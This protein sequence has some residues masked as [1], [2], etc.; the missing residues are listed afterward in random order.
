[1][2]T[3]LAL[4][5]LCLPGRAEDLAPLPAPS[6][7]HAVGT[8]V[9]VLA[10]PERAD[11]VEPEE[12]PRTLVVQLWYPLAQRAA[13][14]SGNR[15]A[16]VDGELLAAFDE[17]SYYGQGL[18]VLADWEGRATHALEDAP[19]RAGALPL[20]LLSHGLGVSRVHYAALAQDLASHGFA[21]A[22]PDHPHGGVTVL[23]DGRVLASDRDPLLGTAGGFGQRASEWARDL[24]LLLDRLPAALGADVALDTGRV[25]AIGHS[26]GGSAAIEATR[27]DER[28]VAAVNM[29]GG[30]S[31]TLEA[32]GLRGRALVLKAMAGRPDDRLDPGERMLAV[33]RD[34]VAKGDGRLH[35]V[36][37]F[38]AGHLSFSDAPFVMPDTITRFGTSVARREEIHRAVCRVLREYVESHVRGTPSPLLSGG[39][40]EP[41]LDWVF[42]GED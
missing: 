7:P 8:R 31:S 39:E 1:V 21:V 12:G 24:V 3:A 29:D 28:I 32:E 36:A 11:P 23:P 42:V 6:G 10:D 27:L 22:V 40:R 18:E 26:L 15:A 4:L 9:L 35:Y 38:G 25:V 13:G 20:L 30:P 17:L 2:T 41:H 33:W 16:Y 14:A 5:L 37:V 34:L 19:A